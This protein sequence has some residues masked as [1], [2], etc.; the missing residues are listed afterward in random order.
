MHSWF[1]KWLPMRHNVSND[2]WT[3]NRFGFAILLFATLGL[4]SRAAADPAPDPGSPAGVVQAL[5]HSDLDHFGFDAASV[6]SSKPW[7]AP[8]LYARMLKK[9]NQPTPKG[10]AP[11]IEGDL[12]FDAQDTPTSFNVGKVTLADTKAQVE[13]N[14][15][16]DA[17]KRTYTVLLQKIDGSWKVTD[18]NYGKD[19]RLSELLK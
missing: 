16:W 11:D 19:G 14:M 9:V 7:V 8:D 2:N 18:V 1:N 4:V 15:K 12:F 6:K 17:E 10:D 5:Y 13:V 3:M